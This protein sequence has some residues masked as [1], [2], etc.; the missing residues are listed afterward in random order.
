[1][2]SGKRN[3]MVVNKLLQK[4][5]ADTTIQVSKPGKVWG[6]GGHCE[7]HGASREQRHLET[8]GWEEMGW[9]R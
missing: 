9:E 5:G 3:N 2:R 8:G 6:N 1:M 7:K 4:T